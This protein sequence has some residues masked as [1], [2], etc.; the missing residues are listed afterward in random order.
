M[1]RLIDQWKDGHLD[2]KLTNRE[3][4]NNFINIFNSYIIRYMYISKINTL[5][6]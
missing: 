3:A 5:Y 2:N 4:K 1:Y 6:V